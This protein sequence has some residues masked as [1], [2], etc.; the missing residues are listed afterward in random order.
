MPEL[1]KPIIKDE[2]IKLSLT[3]WK[4]TFIEKTVEGNNSDILDQKAKLEEY[5]NWQILR[6]N[7]KSY[8]LKKDKPVSEQLEDKVWTILAR[9]GFDEM[10][11]GRN[12]TIDVGDGVNPRQIDVFAKDDETVIF[13]ECTSCDNLTKKDLSPLIEKIESIAPKAIKSIQKQYDRAKLKIR[14]VIAT[15]NI[16]WGKED[17]KKAEKARIHIIKDNEI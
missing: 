3:K 2:N 6:K 16:E 13:I 4:K 10:S 17:I 7:K 1:L 14:W 11:D 15:E 9:M 8:R 5:D 12:F